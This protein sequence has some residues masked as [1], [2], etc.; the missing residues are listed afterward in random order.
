MAH[1]VQ[2]SFPYLVTGE[3]DG[4][5][6]QTLNYTGLIGVL[7]QEIIDIKKELKETKAELMVYINELKDDKS[8]Y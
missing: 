4:E 3:K 8:K 6:I 1:E 5:K 2:E 7:V